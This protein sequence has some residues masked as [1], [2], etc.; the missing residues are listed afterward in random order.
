MFL[1]GSIHCQAAQRVF[2]AQAE[3]LSTS[4]SLCTAENTLAPMVA[5]VTSGSDSPK[6]QAPSRSTQGKSFIPDPTSQKPGAA[7]LQWQGRDL[8]TLT[9]GT[10]KNPGVPQMPLFI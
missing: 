10:E 2:F 8:Q 6:Q 1:E 9:T 5:D 4:S 3:S 7:P